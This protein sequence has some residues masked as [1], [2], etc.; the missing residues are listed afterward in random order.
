MEL[1]KSSCNKTHSFCYA[2][3][4]RACEVVDHDGR[5]QCDRRSI[6]NVSV[7]A[8]LWSYTACIIMIII[9]VM[10]NHVMSF[11]VLS[12]AVRLRKIG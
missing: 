2:G 10:I 12:S 9:I 5:S 6:D 3:V 11:L 1:E 4:I 7:P 8:R